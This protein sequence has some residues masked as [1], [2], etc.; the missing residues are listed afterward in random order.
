AQIL[1]EGEL[2]PRTFAGGTVSTQ[3]S[4]IVGGS[5]RHFALSGT[6]VVDRGKVVAGVFVA[7]ELVEGRR[8]VREDVFELS[9]TRLFIEDEGPLPQM[10]AAA[11]EYLCASD[12]WECSVIWLIG[13]DAQLEPVTIHTAGSLPHGDELHE[14]LRAV[15]FA[16]G[17]GLPGRAW[18]ADDVVWI[19]DL[20]EEANV[21]RAHLARRMQLHGAVAVPLRDGARIVGVLEL[22]TRD[23]RPVDDLHAQ[24]LLRTGAGLGRLIERRRTEDERRHLLQV[25]E[26]K[27]L[28]WTLTFDAIEMPIFITE[29]NGLVRRVNRAARD[30]TGR[31]YSDILGRRI[32]R[33]AD[34]EPWLTLAAA[35]EAVRDSGETCTAQAHAADSDRTWDVAANSYHPVDEPPR[36]IV[37]ARETTSVVRLQSAVRRGEQLSALGELV[38]GVAHEVRNPIFGM[39]ITLDALQESV[40]ADADA[41][42]LMSALRSWLARLNGLM[43]SLLAYGRTWTIDLKE[44]AIADV[45]AQALE[46]T[47]PIAGA[48][49]VT[50]RA[51]L[52]A[53]G[54]I[55]M[56]ASRL[57]HAIENLIT[58]AIQHSAAQ[59][60]VLVTLREE[61]GFVECAVRDRGP[62]FNP[63]DLPR[64]FEPFFT[65]RRG[66][67][68]LG[69]AIVQ[70]IVDE[71]GG[72]LRAENA[73]NGGAIV[74][75]RFPV[76]QVKS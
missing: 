61:D 19:A 57:V 72:T 67:T 25:I 62:G 35:V 24:A 49:S 74:T 48:A 33:L 76:Y 39:Q 16:L 27:G 75:A 53:T 5:M 14:Q 60:E 43:E 8:N 12:G 26:R 71:H 51:S 54:P 73:E 11:A 30:L 45:V 70:R 4:V 9:L 20:S 6:P 36:V 21:A 32:R 28:E 47:K 58:N 7:R 65:R 69:L 42:E 68:G 29:M 63:A 59:A 22:F 23:V 31:D 10:L 13:A 44:G 34:G 52:D 56:D 55:L 38:A 1:F 40:P 41:G 64:I 15:R 50:I 46:T 18:Q 66:G 17:R 37:V 3:A 2:F